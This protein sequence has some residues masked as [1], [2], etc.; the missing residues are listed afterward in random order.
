[1][2]SA[3]GN[4]VDGPLTDAFLTRAREVA[5]QVRAALSAA[6]A[7]CAVDPSKPQSLGRALRL[8]KSL[9]WKIARVVTDSDP[10][11][12]VCRLPGRT[13]SKL[14][15]LALGKGGASPAEVESVQS[16]L[17]A[18]EQMI[19]THAGDRETLEIMLAGVMP[20]G[21][22]REE[23]YRKV[24]FVGNSAV[25]GVRARA[26]LAAQFVAPNPAD[27][28]RLDSAIVTAL[29]GLVRLRP[30][31]PWAV[32]T[33]R[34]YDGVGQENVPGFTGAIDPAGLTPDG[35][36]LMPAFCSKPLPTVQVRTLPSGALR[37]EL[38]PVPVGQTAAM[39]C[40][41][42]WFMRSCVPIGRTDVDRF[43]EHIVRVSTPG[44]VVVFDYFV[45]RSMLFAHRP[46]LEVYSMLPGGPVYPLHGRESG[47]LPI[48][49]EQEALDVPNITCDEVEGYSAMID[50]TM[51]RL[52]WDAR[53][54]VG[55]RVR[56][57]Y[58]PVPSMMVLRYELPLLV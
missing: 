42:G 8:D 18:F 4:S 13:G 26:Q 19:A 36:P 52:G 46:E 41:T 50:A 32:A 9:A 5:L 47:R 11:A 38:A 44:E 27:P 14:M 17:L 22:E 25:F 23:Q 53:D 34:A 35:L 21:R 6:L 33:V 30:E 3:S 16:A 58:P 40:V 12:A 10:L 45:H 57:P 1:M 48:G 20:S 55:L 39:D 29:L 2:F 7:S 56:I 51:A 54:F 31:T 24:A 43:G 28:G 15:L 49:V 37:F